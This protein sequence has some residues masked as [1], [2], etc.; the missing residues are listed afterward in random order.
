[1]VTFPIITPLPSFGLDNVLLNLTASPGREYILQASTN[2]LHW[3]SILTNVASLDGLLIFDISK[4]GD[5]ARFF[6]TL[7]R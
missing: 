1:V 6:R 4:T 7:A 3:P 2:L 5:P